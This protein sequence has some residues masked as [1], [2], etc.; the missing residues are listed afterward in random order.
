MRVYWGA[1]VCTRSSRLHKRCD[2]RFARNHLFH[3]SRRDFKNFRWRGS[4]FLNKGVS[5]LIIVRAFDRGLRA[6]WGTE[7]ICVSSAHRHFGLS[8][9]SRLWRLKDIIKFLFVDHRYR[10]AT[11]RLCLSLLLVMVSLLGADSGQIADHLFQL[12][13]NN[14]G[15]LHFIIV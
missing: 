12:R 4:F 6:G 8:L 10:V 15:R 3:V 14:W 1:R 7:L 5:G 9:L 2:I 11:R 13:V